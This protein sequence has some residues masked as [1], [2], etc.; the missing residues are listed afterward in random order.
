[1]QGTGIQSLGWRDPLEKHMAAYSSIIAL[2][3][4]WTEEPHGL[5]SMGSQRVGC[6][7]QTKQQQQQ[8]VQ[9]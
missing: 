1:M 7:L 2:E 5:K 3:I 8:Q 6:D 9:Q 4:S